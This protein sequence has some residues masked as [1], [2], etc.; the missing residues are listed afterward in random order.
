MRLAVVFAGQH[1]QLTAQLPPNLAG[2][3]RKE[4][5]WLKL[6]GWS[7]KGRGGNGR[8]R[9]RK[10]I[11]NPPHLRALQLFSPGCANAVNRALLACRVGPGPQTR[12]SV[13]DLTQLET[14]P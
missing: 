10:G 9:K 4:R 2:E 14:S 12:V 3:N 5:K 1:G 11:G 13:I 7:N 6:E 8:M